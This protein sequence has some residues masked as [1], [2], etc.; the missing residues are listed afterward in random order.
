MIFSKTKDGGSLRAAA[1]AAVV[2]YLGPPLAGIN[3]AWSQPDPAPYAD[4]ADLD[5]DGNVGTADLLVLLS[6]WGVCAEP[7]DSCSADLG[8]NGTV[9]S[10]DLLVMLAA[11]GPCS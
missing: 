7:P 9:E 10:S 5:G 1:L 11:W 3:A 2:L 4:G 8:G 6:D